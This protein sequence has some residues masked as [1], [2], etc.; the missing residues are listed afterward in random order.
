M[1]EQNKDK[2]VFRINKMW[3][4]IIAAVLITLAVAA[5][6]FVYIPKVQ[7]Q[8]AINSYKKDFFNGIVCEY[9]CPLTIQTVKNKT[10]PLPDNECVKNCTAGLMA[11]AAAGD[12]LSNA[13]LIS[14]N[15]GAEITGV[16]NDCKKVGFDNA[17]LS[18]NSSIYFPCVQAKLLDLR[19]NYSYLN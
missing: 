14:D 4:A 18:V 3:L 5:V 19:K 16:T 9:S 17:T 7:K 1:T 6:V 8:N 11:R 15:L 13:D 2:G 10:Q 12:K